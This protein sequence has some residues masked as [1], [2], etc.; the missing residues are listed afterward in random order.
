M[1]IAPCPPFAH[2]LPRLPAAY[3]LQVTALARLHQLS[4][5]NAEYNS[6][7]YSALLHLPSLRHLELYRCHS[8]PA[9][10]S[11]L[12]QLEALVIDDHCGALGLVDPEEEDGLSAT[13]IVAAALPRLQQLTYLALDSTHP[14]ASLPVELTNLT[15]LRSFYW[16]EAGGGVLP[17]GAWLSGVRRLAAVA[18]CVAD[19]LPALAAATRLEF[20]GLHYLN[21]VPQSAVAG[22][23]QGVASLPAMRR[24]LL[25]GTHASFGKNAQALLDAQRQHPHLTFKCQSFET[26]DMMWDAWGAFC[27]ACGYHQPRS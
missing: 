6:S 26:D 9:C 7:G 12:T 11:Q 23:L 10:L 20:L 1:A 18:G 8:L 17:P 4:L 24:I 21:G 2:C 5:I 14:R 15:N 25:H 13:D 27:A 16:L 3:L 19:S 22:M